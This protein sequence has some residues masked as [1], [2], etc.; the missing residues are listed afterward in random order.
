MK[1][2]TRTSARLLVTKQQLKGMI[3]YAL[4]RRYVGYIKAIS[5]ELVVKE[6]KIVVKMNIPIHRLGTSYKDRYLSTAGVVKVKLGT[7][8]KE[9]PYKI[10]KS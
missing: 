3:E 4:R 7:K 2:Y 1:L 6:D 8:M 5:Y 9:N 10:R